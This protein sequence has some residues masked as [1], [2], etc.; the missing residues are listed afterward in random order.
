M[1]R[2]SRGTIPPT[3]TASIERIE[4][5]LL[6]GRYTYSLHGSQNN[7][8]GF[9]PLMILYGGNGTGKTTILSAMFHLLSG[10]QRRGHRTWLG[11]IPFQRFSVSLA[12]GSTLSA[13]RS[14]SASGSYTLEFTRPSVSEPLRAEMVLE[15]SA[16]RAQSPETQS[17]LDTI[18]AAMRDTLVLYYL[19][20]ARLLDSDALEP[21][22]SAQHVFF[23]GELAELSPHDMLVVDERTMERMVLQ[24]RDR[25]KGVSALRFAIKQLE[26]WARAQTLSSNETGDARVMMLYRDIITQIAD[27]SAHRS[28]GSSSVRFQEMLSEIEKQQ[29][30]SQEYAKYGLMAPLDIVALN[31]LLARVPEIHRDVLIQVVRP[32]VDSVRTRLDALD[33]TRK[34]IDVF[35][36]TINKFYIDKQVTFHVKRGL[37]IT[38]T[39]GEPLSPDVLSSGERQ[40]LLLLSSAVAARDKAS[41]FIIDEPE[42]SLNIKWQRKLINALLDCTS[43]SSVQFLIATHSIE[44]LSQFRDHVVTLDSSSR[45]SDGHSAISTRV[46]S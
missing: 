42:L 34:V 40:L 32:F 12:N 26:S 3:P 35:V 41:V 16:P 44:L 37:T 4:V 21:A 24:G 5:E 9:S 46:M 8:R 10:S 22:M 31:P 11:Q 14:K 43:D 45:T 39:D 27:S 17:A 15:G 19:N 7:A 33:S 38:T 30:R 28:D 13:Y 20:D 36:S 1:A 25:R 2:K 18:F 23:E 6:F 29:E